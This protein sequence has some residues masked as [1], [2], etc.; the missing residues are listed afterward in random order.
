MLTL[1]SQEKET[2]KR[3]KIFK[4]RFPCTAFVKIFFLEVRQMLYTSIN[5]TST[6]DYISNGSTNCEG[7]TGFNRKNGLLMQA[8]GSGDF[9]VQ[10]VL[11]E[12]VGVGTAITK[13]SHLLYSNYREEYFNQKIYCKEGLE[14]HLHANERKYRTTLR[15]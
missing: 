11:E 3:I 8:D 9:S 5:D 6:L 14:K 12:L 15:G 10:K 1:L 2:W 4:D 7:G 13:A